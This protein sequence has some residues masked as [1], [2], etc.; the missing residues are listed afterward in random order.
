MNEYAKSF[1]KSLSELFKCSSKQYHT[2][3]RTHTNIC[4]RTM[5]LKI[6]IDILAQMEDKID[7]QASANANDLR[8]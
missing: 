5:N 4:T 8:H 2:R 3:T 1:D 6:T 7:S